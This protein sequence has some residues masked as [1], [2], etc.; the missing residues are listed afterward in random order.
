MNTNLANATSSYDAVTLG[1][2][3]AVVTRLASQTGTGD[4]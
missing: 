4:S 3:E 1:Q 2:F